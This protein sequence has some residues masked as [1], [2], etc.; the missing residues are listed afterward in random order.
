MLDNRGRGESPR[1]YQAY[2][3]RLWQE[4]PDR[5]WRA[6]LQE[7]GTDRRR[8]FSDLERLLAFLYAQTDPEA[9]PEPSREIAAGE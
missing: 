8:G 2:L 9:R 6:S 5:P 7:A 3:L 1:R 4:E